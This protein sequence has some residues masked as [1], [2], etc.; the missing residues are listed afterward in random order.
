MKYMLVYIALLA[1]VAYSQDLTLVKLKDK[2]AKGKTQYHYQWES[3]DGHVAVIDLFLFKDNTFEYS[4]ASNINYMYSTG[5]WKLSNGII[6]L[7]SDI[8]NET[9]P[10]QI[11]YRQR[12][13]SDFN[14]KKIALIRDLNDAPLTYAIM[15]INNDS[16]S[17]MDG[18]LLCVGDYKQIDSIRVAIVNRGP[19]S[20]WIRIYP[21]EGLLQI[22]IPTKRSLERYMVLT[23]EKYLVYK[24]K[25]KALVKE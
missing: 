4:I 16:T 22:T 21:F 8:Q 14:V 6:A 18:D 19:S 9:L 25:L 2:E 5:R 17:C 12:D 3:T 7:N 24:D 13:S 20:K 11:K 23:D 10:I 1:Q 15:Y